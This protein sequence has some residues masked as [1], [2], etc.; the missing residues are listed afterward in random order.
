[1]TV[2]YRFAVRKLEARAGGACIGVRRKS[3]TYEFNPQDGLNAE[4]ARM[5]GTF[6]DTALPAVRRAGRTAREIEDI[7]GGLA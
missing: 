7:S 6:L 1:M 3:V 4:V 5:V 2:H